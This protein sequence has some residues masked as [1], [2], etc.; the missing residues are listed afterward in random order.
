MAA[1]NNS[2]DIMDAMTSKPKNDG[3]VSQDTFNG[4]ADKVRGD[5]K[6]AENAVAGAFTPGT[7]SGI[8][9]A[10]QTHAN[11]VHPVGK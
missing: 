8:D 9:Q 1:N 10:M 6:G 4:I 7:S 5:I 3:I 2:V 11:K